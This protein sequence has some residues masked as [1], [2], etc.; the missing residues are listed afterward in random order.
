SAAS[1]S[2][3]DGSIVPSAHQSGND[4]SDLSD[5]PPPA[6]PPAS[7]PTKEEAIH[8][9]RF[10]KWYGAMTE[11][12]ALDA[13]MKK[14]TSAAY[15]HFHEPE[16]VHTFHKGEEVVQYKFMCKVDD[17]SSTI[18]SVMRV[19]WD[20]STSNLRR[21]IRICDEKCGA[22]TGQSNIT[23][24]AQ[25]ST[26]SKAEFRFVISLWIARR[27]RPHVIVQ[28]PELL[29]LFRMLYAKVEV[30]SPSTVSRDVR[31]I[32]AISRIHI[33]T[34]LKSYIL[35]FVKLTSSH[36][37]SYL[38]KRLAECL[39][40]YG[41]EKKILGITADNASNNDTLISEL[42]SL[43][44]ANSSHTRVRCFAHIINLVVK[45]LLT[46]F[47]SKR[48]TDPT[49]FMT[50]SEAID[51]EL[52]ELEDEDAAAD[53]DLL[54][55]D[56]DDPNN[57]D[58]DE[59]ET[60]E[61]REEDDTRIV[62]QVV[63][64][65]AAED[66]EDIDLD[67]SRVARFAITKLSQLAKRVFHS[68]AICADLKIQCESCKIQPKQMIRSVATRWNSTSESITR[69]LE[70]Q[71]ALNKLLSL[72]KYERGGNKSL[73]RFK[74][75]DAEWTVLEELKPLLKYFLLAT[76]RISES[77]TPLLHNVI[78]IIDVLT[79]RL[80]ATINNI[81]LTPSVRLAAKRGLK[82]LNKY[83]SVT[84]ESVMYRIAM[85]LHPCYKTEYF[86][87]QLWE[88]AWI[89]TALDILREQ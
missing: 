53:Q 64:A 46:P 3:P 55:A 39:R 34:L 26:Y 89:D 14:W 19:C 75:T 23:D 37:G 87:R 42:E 17:S 80:Q 16:I 76:K 1:A 43:G 88:T 74:N 66:V 22:K 77:D 67:A 85:L 29:H 68:P 86:K 54:A 61:G 56:Q 8:I 30:P 57:E 15:K 28:D 72:S 83:Y 18:Q 47:T 59:F 82:V 50:D 65:V 25:G 62:N 38:A 12:Q 60:E 32:F 6:P 81:T 20:D 27:H 35:D 2:S 51:A 79:E 24:F 10:R 49:S 5:G 33:A 45:A 84:D 4:S 78:P 71:L 11:E 44:G 21:H 9:Q 69:A 70:L 48:R 52:A 31:E 63:A 7:Q 40:E 58:E 73:K 13:Q 36:T 41:I